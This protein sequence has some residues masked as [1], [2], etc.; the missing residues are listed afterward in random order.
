MLIFFFNF[1]Q[2]TQSIKPGFFLL[3]PWWPISVLALRSIFLGHF[4]WSYFFKLLKLLLA[5][6]FFLLPPPN[7][8][9]TLCPFVLA[10]FLCR[11]LFWEHCLET[12]LTN[13]RDRQM[14]MINIKYH[15]TLYVGFIVSVIKLLLWVLEAMFTEKKTQ[16]KILKYV[17][18]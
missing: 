15:I 4:F 12:F 17:Y 18:K 14:K 3:P 6:F 2:D 16:L 8:P 13:Y 11:A 9:K 1:A 10:L 7:V 5:E